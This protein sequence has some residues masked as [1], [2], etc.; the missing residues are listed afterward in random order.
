MTITLNQLGQVSLSVDSVDKAERFYAEIL[1]LRKLYRFGNLV[2]FD[3]GGVR[4]FIEQSTSQ[5]FIPTGSILYFR[6][7][8]ISQAFREYSRKGV[9]FTDKP[10]LIARMED[11]DL[12]MAFFNDPAG[13]TLALMNEAPKGYKLSAAEAAG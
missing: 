3:C 5:P 4:L 9:V 11:H 1:G 12:W 6:V 13:N 8:D 2:F 7:T 10:H